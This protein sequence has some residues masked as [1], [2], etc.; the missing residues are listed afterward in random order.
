MLPKF[1][2]KKPM[3]ILV[4][5]VLIIALGLVS[6]TKMTPDLLPDIEMPYVVVAT[7]YIGASPEKV[8]SDVTKPIEQALS[9]LDNV[10]SMT[11]TSSDNYSMIIMQFSNDADMEI[12]S[13]NIREE[14]DSISGDWNEYVGT[15]YILKINPTMIPVMTAAVDVEGASRAELSN[16]VN[17]TLL[18]RLEGI[19]GVASVT[20][21]GTITEKV[22]VIINEDKI[23]AVNLRIARAL[24]ETFDENV[25]KLIDAK[26]QLSEGIQAAKDGE[27]QIESGRSQIKAA[28]NDIAK[29]LS[30]AR[31][32]LDSKQTEI[33]ETRSLLNEKRLE[34]TDQLEELIQQENELNKADS[35]IKQLEAG[36][37]EYQKFIDGLKASGE[38]SAEIYGKIQYAESEIASLKYQ[39]SQVE[40][41]LSANGISRGTLS[42]TL[43][44]IRVARSQ[45][46][47]GIATLK[48]TDEQL[49]AG[50][51]SIED[52]RKEVNSKEAESGLEMSGKIAEIIVGE[53]TISDTL[54]DLNDKLDELDETAETI[55]D[56]R[57]DA[58]DSA[59]MTD[60]ITIETVA[61]ILG[62]Q[63]FEMPAGYITEEGTKWLVRVGD[64][65]DGEEELAG[66]AL[67]DTGID[68]VG[69]IYLSDVADII[70]TDNTDE[71]YAK[72]NGK[73]GVLL[74]F[75]KQS[76]AATADV[77]ANIDAR[78]EALTEDYDGLSFTKLLDQGKYINMVIGSVLDNLLIGAALAVIILFLFLKDIRPTIVIA[79]SIPISVMFAIVLMYFSG[80]SLNIISLSG[81]AIGV[82]MLVDNSI[83]VI[84]NIYRLRGKGVSVLKAAVTG[85]VQMTG[86]ITASTLT[87]VC[88]F[89][90]I[91]FVEGITRQLFTDMTLTI[92]YSLMASLVIAITLVPAMASG[93]LKK[94]NQKEQK[95]FKGLLRIYEKALKFSLANRI[96]VLFVVVALLAGS[97]LLTLKRGYSFMPSMGSTEIMVNIQMPDDFV[98]ADTEVVADQ[99]A[100]EILEL[101]GVTSIGSMLSGGMASVIGTG[102]GTENDEGAVT[103]YAILED[104]ANP[105]KLMKQVEELL[106]KYDVTGNVSGGTDMTSYLT[107]LSGS[108]VQ[109][110]VFGEDLDDMRDAAQQVADRLEKVEGI[111][112]VDNGMEETTP[113]LHITVDKNAA[114]K[115]GLTIAQVYQDL[116]FAMTES[117]DVGDLDEGT[118]SRTL[119]VGSDM[120]KSLGAQ[121]IRDYEIDFTAQDG[122]KKTVKLADIAEIEESTSLASINRDEQ[123]RVITVSGTLDSDYNVSLVTADAEK[124]LKDLVLPEGCE[125]EFDG[126]N[127]IITDALE[128]LVKMLLLGVLVVYLIMV[129]QFQSLMS[130][131][132]VMFTI[133]LAFTGGLLALLVSGFELSVISL[134]GFVMLVGVIVNN[135]IV[136]VDGINQLR[137]DGMERRKAILEAA[138]TRLR[139]VLM[140]ALTTILGLLPMMLGLGSGSGLVQP[141]AVVC[142]GGLVYAT[143]MT[144]FVV[145]IMYELLTKKHMRVVKDDELEIVDE[146]ALEEAT[147]EEK[148]EEDE[149]FKFD[150]EFN[151]DEK[152]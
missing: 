123:R 52:A 87:T 100:E 111:T 137:A 135:G 23:D 73:D 21:S 95:G 128:Q 13:L 58:K 149:D 110:K 71:T 55:E 2:V 62:A 133:P 119:V 45:I 105:E 136:L 44:Q 53:Q 130:P 12:V 79:F 4:A 98:L 109:V 34:L 94:I 77:S 48:T 138:T 51:V 84:E 144:L 36:I 42:D 41:Q 92:T 134:I 113:E 116:A 50:L 27:K 83:V 121:G 3:T 124:Q 66:M 5:V 18:Q 80:V 146:G 19:E 11:S 112:S 96:I 93:T 22:N 68:D 147:E 132:V 118:Y 28:Q 32:E 56:A 142:V 107:S 117:V 30:D 33:L 40:S 8:E 29:Q 72:I 91:V 89:A 17:N 143:F 25:A 90:P 108:G 106:E 129:A 54:D 10:T 140:T 114:A 69:V 78:F 64:D 81:L 150:I 145:P 85:A 122:T 47:E 125:I 1:S 104:N 26:Q 141:I 60:K 35:G 49:A 115:E 75:Q 16:F 97:L 63:N 76:D 46:E 74:S 31:T 38:Y 6:F 59:D 82:G 101:D 61:T 88:V 65:I 152:K 148:V 15:P 70:I 39:L 86:A 57:T 24:D 139:P 120:V 20:T 67:F 126:E 103:M 43:R 151:Q 7:T 131:F 99:I 127:S 102:L 9:T 37:N 14:I